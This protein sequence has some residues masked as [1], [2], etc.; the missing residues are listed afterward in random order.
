MNLFQVFENILGYKGGNHI[1]LE[2]TITKETK[3]LIPNLTSNHKDLLSTFTN[4][5]HV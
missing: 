2:M 3:F 4:N 1:Q 5:T